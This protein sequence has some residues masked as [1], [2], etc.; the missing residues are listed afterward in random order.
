M[1]NLNTKLGVSECEIG[2]VWE[3]LSELRSS[4]VCVELK[5]WEKFLL[6]LKIS[7]GE[8]LGRSQIM[9][10]SINSMTHL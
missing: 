2:R 6:G 5:G 10:K 1:K 3:N 4:D 9:H 7:E 8:C